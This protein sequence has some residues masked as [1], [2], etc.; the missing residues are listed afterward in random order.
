[1]SAASPPPPRTSLLRAS[2]LLAAANGTAILT[3]LLTGPVLARTLGVDGRGLLA[4]VLVPLSLASGLTLLSAGEYATQQVARGV[5]ASTAFVS[6]VPLVLAGAGAGALVLLLVAEPLS[7]GESIVRDWLVVGALS[8]PLGVL[9]PLGIGVAGGLERWGVVAA[10]QSAP[11]LLYAV[12]VGVLAVLGEL[13]V[14]TA[15]AS[16]LVT[17]VLGALPLLV[18]RRGPPSSRPRFDRAVLS[19]G[20]AYGLRALG[21]MLAITLNT[22]LDQMLMLSLSSARQLGL[23]AVAVTIAGIATSLI[24]S[25]GGAMVPR[26]AA[27]DRALVA[28]ACRT[29]IGLAAGSCCLFGILTYPVLLVLFGREFTEA[30]PMALVLLLAQVPG[31]GS[32]VLGYGLRASGFPGRVSIADVSALVVTLPALFLLVPRLGGLGAALASL[33]AYALTFVVLALVART[34]LGVGMRDMMVPRK[35]EMLDIGRRIAGAVRARI[36]PTSDGR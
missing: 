23:Y 36:K 19:G 16:F 15:V 27:G 11:P 6:L 32:L 31:V 3:G 28:R 1:M 33:C 26:V 2:S 18:L 21:G 8:L 34:Q 14:G 30:L 25:L 5:R 35:G 29:S 24:V 13:T 7:D 20:G 17:S 9:V 10:C 22:R 12:S 4:A